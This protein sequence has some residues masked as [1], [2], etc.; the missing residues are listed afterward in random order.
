MIE[1]N[2]NRAS[3][4][5]LGKG[6]SSSFEIPSLIEAQKSS[7]KDFYDGG[8]HTNA[9]GSEKCSK[10]FAEYMINHYDFIDMRG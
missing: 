4:L 5:N 10:F 6:F 8:I 9:I 7:F 1:P 3:R 2:R